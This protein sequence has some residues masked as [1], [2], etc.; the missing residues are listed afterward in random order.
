MVIQQAMAAGLTVIASNICGVPYQIEHDVTGLLFEPGNL[1][2]L[3][4]LLSRLGEDPSLSRRLGNASI[5]VAS[6]RFHASTVA[7]ATRRAYD[8]ALVNGR[9]GE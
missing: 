7:A 4:S 6:A 8:L 3:S 1:V 9:I 5:T 2:Q